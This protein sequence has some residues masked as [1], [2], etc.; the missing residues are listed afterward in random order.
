V[1]L[2]LT[3]TLGLLGQF[4]IAPRVDLALCLAK[5][6]QVMFGVLLKILG[7]HA[8]I[9]QLCVAGQLIVFFDDLLGRATHL[10]L[11]ARAFEHPVDD[12]DA[13]P[14]VAV[15]ASVAFVPRTGLGR[16]HVALVPALY[17]GNFSGA[18]RVGLTL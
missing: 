13:R 11:W 14:V 12:I 7:G 4:L 2:L 9:A 5:K 3:V 8:I 18:R 1:M 16:S 6:T 15:V 10:A 17:P